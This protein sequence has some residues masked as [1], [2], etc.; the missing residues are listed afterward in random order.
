VRRAQKASRARRSVLVGHDF[1]DCV[2]R[3]TGSGAAGLSFD[4]AHQLAFALTD[5]GSLAL[6]PPPPPP[7]PS[8]VPEPA[9]WA[10]MI[11]GFALL[12]GA[13]RGRRNG[14]PLP[15]AG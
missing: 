10:M 8:A 4:L 1:V 14:L 11:G 7:S 6:P 5:G 3:Q 9:S 12:G 13:L 2:A 15:L